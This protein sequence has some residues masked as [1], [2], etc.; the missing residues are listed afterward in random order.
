MLITIADLA[1][2]ID[3]PAWVVVDCRFNLARPDAG[4]D[5]YHLSHIPRARYAHLDRDLSA[6]RT[7]DSGRHPLPDARQLRETFSRWGI[8]AGSH[9]VAYDDAGGAFA[10]R[11]WWL[12]RWLGHAQAGLL[13]GGLPAWLAAGLPTTSELPH[14]RAAHF[15]GT[16]GH[17]LTVT[18]EELLHRLGTPGLRLLDARA[19]NR[20]HG[21]DETIDPVAGHV[22]GAISAPFQ[23]NL[24]P[25]GTFRSAAELKASYAGVIDGADTD[26]V[27]CMCGSGVTACHNI[28]AMELAGISDVRLYPGSWSEWIRSPERPIAI[29]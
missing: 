2:H 10:A 19:A 26:G 9:V 14:D 1:A 25:S 28:F 20:F 24:T 13:D 18:A 16:P 5:A 27:A 12:L 15:T 23:A 21:R 8:D 17:M 22:P 7:A 29:D 3:D 4:R 6:R 11:L